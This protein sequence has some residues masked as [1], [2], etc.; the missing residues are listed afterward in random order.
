M[1]NDLVVAEFRGPGTRKELEI[2]KV[3]LFEISSFL[4]E[5]SSERGKS[6][7]CGLNFIIGCC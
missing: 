3:L 7:V 5:M 2:S 1:V 6:E 4:A